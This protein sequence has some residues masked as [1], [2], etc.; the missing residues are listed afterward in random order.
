LG[1][2]KQYT[3]R[4]TLI[5]TVEKLNTFLL[6]TILIYIHFQWILVATTMWRAMKVQVQC[7]LNRLYV[8]MCYTSVRKSGT[9]IESH[10]VEGEVD[11]VC[12][13]VTVDV[14]MLPLLALWH[15][16]SIAAESVILEYLIDTAT[17]KA[18]LCPSSVYR[19]G[20]LQRTA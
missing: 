7:R 12:F 11:H 1:T 13:F 8:Y 10:L 3:I 2:F 17:T 9:V 20:V 16:F 14:V 6:I 5:S 4:R 18:I 15:A 19:F